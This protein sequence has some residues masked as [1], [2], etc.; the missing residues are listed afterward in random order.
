LNITFGEQSRA[1]GQDRPYLLPSVPR[2]CS[3][4]FPV[5]LWRRIIEGHFGLFLAK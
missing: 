4:R 3:K 5:K 1:A 2:N